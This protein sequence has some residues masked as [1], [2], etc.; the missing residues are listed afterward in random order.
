MDG[1]MVRWKNGWFDVFRVGW[2]DGCM[3][4]WLDG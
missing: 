3:D 4:V 1:L 2:L